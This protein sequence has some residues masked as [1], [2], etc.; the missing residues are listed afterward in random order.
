M[1]AI[2]SHTVQDTAP[3]VPSPYQSV[4]LN[5]Y[6]RHN[7]LIQAVAG[8]GKSKTLELLCQQ[9]GKSAGRTCLLA[10]NKTIATVLKNRGLP[11]STFNSLGYG[12]VMNAFKNPVLDGDK[13]ANTVKGMMTPKDMKAIGS[14]TINLV[15]KAYTIGLVPDH[16]MV[17]SLSLNP[18]TKEYAGVWQELIDT[19]DI[20]TTSANGEIDNTI[21]IIEA[22]R[23]VLAR[24][25]ATTNIVS[26]DDQISFP[27]LYGLPMRQYDHL[28]VDEAQDTNLV[29]MAFL[30]KAL[31]RNGRFTAVGDRFQSLYMFRG[32]ASDAMDRIKR[33]FE[34]V[35]YPLS[36]CYRCP[37]KVVE[38]AKALV[39]QIE[40]A[41]WKGE[42]IVEHLEKHGPSTYKT[43]D[44]IV[45]RK[46]AD[47][48]SMAYKLMAAR[49]PCGILGRDM[50]SGLI[51]LMRK[52]ESNYVMQGRTENQIEFL[53]TSL[54]SWRDREVQ[55]AKVK[56]DEGKIQA[57]TDKFDT[58]MVIIDSS[59]AI[60]IS[61]VINE[62][63]SMFSADKDLEAMKRTKVVLMTIHKSKGD[64]APR[65]FWLERDNCPSGWARTKEQEHTELCIQ[66]VA[67]T[68]AQEALY[69]IDLSGW[70]V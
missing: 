4:I 3:I 43:G 11:A 22:S 10:F 58:M 13:V 24:C 23:D 47:L 21:E 16:R 41:E 60:T 53:I 29:Q 12:V 1:N 9:I 32:A 35:E 70:N 18:V 51:T 46:N 44:I 45:S 39:P 5:N 57:I 19:Y 66:Y 48:V 27:V 54:E 6:D 15:S 33:E 64:E 26:F 36:I 50:I 62:C 7:M 25:L 49:V 56:D 68:R 52:I 59:D 37:K 20:D 28:M 55:K 31:A 30:K 38:V 69:Y 34:C 65:I 17:R 67:I 63:L 42:G 40:A 61:S 8:S 14:A 2:S